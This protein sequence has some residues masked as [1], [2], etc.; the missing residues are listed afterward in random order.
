[1]EWGGQQTQRVVLKDSL[2]GSAWGDAS[3]TGIQQPHD[4]TCAVPLDFPNFLLWTEHKALFAP[5]AETTEKQGRQDEETAA[6]QEGV[7]RAGW[8]TQSIREG[9][10]ILQGKELH[11]LSGAFQESMRRRLVFHFVRLVFL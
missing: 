3:G 6:T 7:S 10:Q 9:E 2:V 8:H 5:A 11:A 1:M 4:P